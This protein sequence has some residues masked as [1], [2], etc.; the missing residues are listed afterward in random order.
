[1]T[2]DISKP[3]MNNVEIKIIE[4]LLKPDFECFEWGC[5]GSTLYY[6]KFVKSW[7]SYEH[8]PE[9]YNEVKKK[10]PANVELHLVSLE[11]YTKIQG[12][13]DFILIDGANRGEC[14]HEAV[15]HIKPGGNPTFA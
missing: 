7:V 14:L 3:M 8:D 2:N 5:G 4:G 12:I 10:K 13:Y 11:N 6:P 9:Y 1:M 15:K